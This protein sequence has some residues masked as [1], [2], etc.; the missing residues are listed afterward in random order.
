MR[1]TWA[2]IGAGSAGLCA[3]KTLLDHGFAVTVFEVGSHVGGL[4]VYGNDSGLSP[5]Y[6]SLHINSEARVSCY[7][8][9]PFPADTPFY[10]THAEMHAYFQA[11]AE[12][13]DLLRHIRFRS[14][15]AAIEPEGH[16]WTVR[17]EGGASERFDAV[18]VATG[19]QGLGRH[20]REVEGF[21]GEY[22]H[23]HDYRTPEP[24][25]GKRV[26]VIG[27]GNSGLDIAADVCLTAARTVLSARHAVQL[28]F[29]AR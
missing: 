20:P 6:R 3:A 10:P 22:L 9:M 1:K 24:F 21:T 17:L 19:H 4:W 23:S 26:L 29:L 15:V 27:T 13:F 5:A 18:I 28:E 7:R 8:A 2:I 14:R 16:G 11:Y 12:R 25:A